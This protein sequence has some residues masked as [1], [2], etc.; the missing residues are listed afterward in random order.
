MARGARWWFKTTGPDGATPL[1]DGAPPLPLI[2]EVR[3][4]LMNIMTGGPCYAISLERCG[5]DDETYEVLRAPA[6]AANKFDPP[7][8]STAGEVCRERLSHYASVSFPLT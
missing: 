6:V 1:L 3:F 2:P 5:Y 8:P 7:Q 4:L